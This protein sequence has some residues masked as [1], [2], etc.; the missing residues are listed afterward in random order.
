MLRLE[1]NAKASALNESHNALAA[2]RARPQ[3]L[4]LLVLLLEAATGANN[5][6]AHAI[7]E[8]HNDLATNRARVH[9]DLGNLHWLELHV[10]HRGLAS[11][12]LHNVGH[13]GLAKELLLNLRDESGPP[14]GHHHG[15]QDA[16]AAA[17]LHG[18]TNVAALL[19]LLASSLAAPRTPPPPLQPW[20]APRRGKRR[21]SPCNCCWAR[22]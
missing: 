13:H 5:A 8:I 14:E 18:A 1:N 9:V 11:E 20:H 16:L 7:N 4:S 3:L 2:N 15:V 22:A 10:G 19:P 6:N 12:L 17:H 21:R